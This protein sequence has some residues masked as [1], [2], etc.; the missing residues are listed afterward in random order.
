M[1]ARGANATMDVAFEATYGVPPAS[2]FFRTPFVSSNLGEEQG[3][4]AS[5]VLGFGRDPQQP[6]RGAVDNAGDLVVPI[7]ARNIG[8]WLKMMFGDPTT[9]TGVAASGT[10]TFS[11]Q[12][13][14]NATITVAGQDFT[15][16]N[17]TPTANQIKIGSTLAETV[18]NAVR[19][20]NA[21]AVA[22][23]AAATYRATS[24]ANAI[25]IVHDTLGTS[26]NSFALA[27]GSSPASNA[28][29]SGST[30]S[31]GAGSGGYRHTFV[32]GA[33]TLPSASVQIGNPEVPNYGMNWGAKANTL[34]VSLARSG[35]LNATIGLIAQG[36]TTATTDQAGTP[37]ELAL[38]KFSHFAGSVLR[39]GVPIADLISGQLNVSNGA[40]GVPAIRDDGRV[41]G[42]DEGMLAAT[43]QVGI[44]Y[45]T[46]ELQVLA[47]DGTATEL[48]YAWTIPNTAFAL[49]VIVHTVYLPRPKRPITGP[50]GIVADYSWQGAESP[51]LH[52]TITVELTNDVASY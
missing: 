30:L 20:L 50:T 18:A 23:V 40:E 52:K 35:N 36:E 31:G 13:A 46:R 10:I 6:G 41:S 43:G 26:G 16:V 15:F 8:L 3:L 49:R 24:R 45:G 11:A 1:R 42:V 48:E 7:C 19:A 14:N 2:G 29:V 47:E 28:T 22:G 4:E 38:M 12:P 51:T 44:R 37:T 25:R 5:D 27:A 39:D 33:Q 9:A 34:G 17:G 32:G 21:S